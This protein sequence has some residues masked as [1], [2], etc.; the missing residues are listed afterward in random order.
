MQTNQEMDKIGQDDEPHFFDITP[1]QLEAVDRL[2]AELD[3]DELHGQVPAA[4][5]IVDQQPSLAFEA[6]LAQQPND[7]VNYIFLS[8]RGADDD[9]ISQG[10]NIHRNT[11][12]ENLAM[13]DQEDEEDDRVAFGYIP[14]DQNGAPQG[15]NDDEEDDDEQDDETTTANGFHSYSQMDSDPEDD[16]HGRDNNGDGDDEDEGQGY[17]NYLQTRNADGSLATVVPVI[18]SA[19]EIDLTE[20][21]APAAEVIPDDDLN[22][23]AQVMSS[24]SL[25]PP[26]WARAIPEDRWLPKIVQQVE[27]AATTA[28]AQ[29]SQSPAE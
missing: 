16:H 14:L 7:E 15:Y 17:D 26:E 19:V 8:R 5:R 24:F 25:P 6:A 4:F 2:L 11:F 3:L 18:P 13:S 22:T 23:I 28:A 12:D 29:S 10:S 9:R 20:I 1:E 21:S 27:K